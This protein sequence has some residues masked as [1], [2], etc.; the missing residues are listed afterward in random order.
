MN[1]HFLFFECLLY[2]ELY[3]YGKHT[4]E[5]SCFDRLDTESAK[6]IAH[7]YFSGKGHMQGICVGG[8]IPSYFYT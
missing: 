4:I 7:T 8:N 1:V 2:Y 6:T 3:M 5:L